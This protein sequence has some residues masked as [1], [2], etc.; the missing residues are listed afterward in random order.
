MRF[1]ESRQSRQPMFSTGYDRGMDPRWIELIE[2]GLIGIVVGESQLG[3]L[4]S[5]SNG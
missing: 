5:A 4:G 2:S 1:R 3:Y